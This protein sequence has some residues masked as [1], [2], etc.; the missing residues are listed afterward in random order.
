MIYLIALK[1]LYDAKILSDV[2]TSTKSLHRL[3]RFLS[4]LINSASLHECYFKLQLKR[5]KPIYIRSKGFAGKSIVS[6]D[7]NV[8]VVKL[9]TLSVYVLDVNIRH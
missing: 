8:S 6:S 2:D 7:V 5:S 9:D 4:N 3:P 1:T